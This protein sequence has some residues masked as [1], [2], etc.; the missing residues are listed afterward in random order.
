MIALRR[1]RSTD[2]DFAERRDE[3]CRRGAGPGATEDPVEATV[4]TILDDVR[5][6]G[7]EAVRAHTEAFDK[8]SPDPATG[9]YEVAA[10]RWHAAAGRVAPEVARALQRAAGRIA[11]FHRP[12]LPEPYTLERGALGLRTVPL[13]RVGVYAPGGTARYPSSVLMTAVPARIAGVREIVLVTPDASPEV[14]LAA[15]L[16]GVSR[17]FE[18]GGA[19]AIGALAY[20]TRSVPRVDKIVGPGSQWVATAKRLVFGL[21]DIDSVAGPSEVLIAADGDADPRWIAA[22]LLAQAEHDTEAHPVLVVI[23]ESLVDRVERELAAQLASLPRAEIAR[24]ALERHGA[25]VV[26]GSVDE[27]LA[28]A[29]DYAPEHLE[30]LVAGAAALAQK[31]RHAGAVFVGPYSPEAAGDYLAGPNH[32]LPTAG[33]ARWASPLGVYD[34][35]KRVTVIHYQRADLAAQWQD[36]ARLASV[37]GLDAHARSV[38]ARFSAGDGEGTDGE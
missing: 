22:D 29:D 2:P 31:V 36:I 25:A 12:Q 28:L 16:A 8:R 32:V 11:A 7:D 34:F 4:R 10:E 18:L 15:R 35:V 17:V 3:L 23:D 14:L 37:E 13:D 1:L 30:L 26:V 21:V 38:S 19:Q 24:A 27:M 5:R 33:S 20:G 6:R 9:T